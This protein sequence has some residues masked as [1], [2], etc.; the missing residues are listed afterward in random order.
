MRDIPPS[1]GP[2]AELAGAR[3]AEGGGGCHSHDVTSGVGVRLGTSRVARPVPRALGPHPTSFAL[4]FVLFLSFSFEVRL[5]RLAL[6]LRA[7]SRSV[8]QPVSLTVAADGSGGSRAH[9][10]VRGTS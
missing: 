6:Y 4:D 8:L 2:A 5:V 10:Q 9:N 3:L 7:T 1:H